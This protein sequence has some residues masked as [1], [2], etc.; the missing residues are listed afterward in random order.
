VV[1][2]ADMEAFSDHWDFH[3]EPFAVWCER[4]VE[5]DDFDPS[6]W[7]IAWD[8]D[9]VAGFSLNSWHS[10]GDPTY[11]WIHVLGVRRRWRR[12]GLGSALLRA[13]FREFGRRGGT[14]VGLAVDAENLAGAVALYE[15]VGMRMDRRYDVYEKCLSSALVSQP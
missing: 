11:G 5:R 8:G 2:E 10:S 9:E 13:S 15:R 3:V 7:L 1:Y 4:T 12:R 6:L 14:R